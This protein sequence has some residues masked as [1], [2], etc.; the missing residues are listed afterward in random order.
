MVRRC[1]TLLALCL[2]GACGGDSS[3]TGGGGDSSGGGD[4]SG[5]DDPS[6]GVRENIGPIFEESRTTLEVVAVEGNRV[7]VETVES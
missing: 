3:P 1:N 2:L 6:G 4:G 7:V 5:G